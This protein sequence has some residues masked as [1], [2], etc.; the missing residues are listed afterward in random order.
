M[1]YKAQGKKIKEFRANNLFNIASYCCYEN[2][3]KPL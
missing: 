3:K 2:H 1:E